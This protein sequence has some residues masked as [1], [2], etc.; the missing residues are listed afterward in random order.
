[1]SSHTSPACASWS[2]LPPSDTECGPQLWTFLGS[3]QPCAEGW[4]APVRDSPS[5]IPRAKC[6]LAA[7]GPQG[8]GCLWLGSTCHRHRLLA[9]SPKLLANASLCAR[10]TVRPNDTKTSEFGEEKGLLSGHARRRV[11]CAPKTLNSPKGFSK[12]SLKAR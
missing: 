1:M 12:A 7:A 10:R 11:A 8:R 5:K 6:T 2:D 9:G 4:P 3:E